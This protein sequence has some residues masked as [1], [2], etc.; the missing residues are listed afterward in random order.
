MIIILIIIVYIVYKKYFTTKQGFKDY[1]S[2]SLSCK[3]NIVIKDR[4][5]DHINNMNNYSDNMNVLH[6][7]SVLPYNINNIDDYNILNNYGIKNGKKRSEYKH[8]LNGCTSI[9]YNSHKLLKN[10]DKEFDETFKTIE[11]PKW[12]NYTT[13]TYFNSSK[14]NPD[15]IFLIYEEDTNLARWSYPKK[16]LC[17][18]NLYL[19]FKF[20]E[21]NKYKKVLLNTDIDTE[22]FKLTISKFKERNIYKLESKKNDIKVKIHLRLK[23]DAKIIIKSNSIFI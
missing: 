23:E 21:N 12:N 5:K 3:K 16:D 4:L 1:D 17:N 10:Y 19:Y 15:K 7:K 18:R 14:E 8:R 13:K 9:P 2:N 20:D 22:Y 11:I 6:P